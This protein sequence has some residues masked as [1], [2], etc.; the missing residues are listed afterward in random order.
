[1]RDKE[2]IEKINETI[3]FFFKDKIDKLLASFT[4]KNSERTQIKI[5]NILVS[6]CGFS[7]SA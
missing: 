3:A 4:K 7:F 1:M 5:G 6:N 2:T